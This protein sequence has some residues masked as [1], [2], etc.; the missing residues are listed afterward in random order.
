M[1]S[2]QKIMIESKNP[3]QGTCQ[4]AITMVITQ[5][6]GGINQILDLLIDM[7]IMQEQALV[8]HLKGST[9]GVDRV[10]MTERKLFKSD[11]VVRK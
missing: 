2:M 7:L 6:S 4:E 10:L 5:A 9:Q 3:K 1:K 11:C 8:S